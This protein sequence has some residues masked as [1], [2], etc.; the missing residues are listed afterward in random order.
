MY[1]DLTAE[2][3]KS[4]LIGRLSTDIQVNEGSYTNDMISAVAYE[5]W[6]VYQSLDALIPIA[7]VDSTSGEYID[8]RCSEYGI[9]RKA[10]TSAKAKLNFTGT[11][12]T[13]IPAGTVF[14]TADGL[15]FETDETVTITAGVATVNTTAVEIG[16]GY[17]VDV[18]TITQKLISLSGLSTVTNEKATGGTDPE[19]DTALVKRLNDYLQSP[20][21][22]GNVAHY[23]Q[24]ALSVNGVGAV[25]VHPLWDGPGTVKV[26]IVD[27]EKKPVDLTI[28][29]NCAEYIESNRPIG[30]TVT[31]ESAQ[32]LS[33]NIT[34]TIIID[35]STTLD[36]VK[37]EFEANLKVY[38]KD[39]SFEK[40]TIVYNRIVYMLLDIS[41][42]TDY[43]SLT[44][45]GGTANITIAENQV[46]VLQNVE[47]IT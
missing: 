46:P 20:A 47:V 40:Y 26:L 4:D 38:L 22:S 45:N 33:V 18:G 7:F 31:V 15:Q 27:N 24:W 39:L 25:K 44:I 23:K 8:K 1:E 12:G 19:T 13:L 34:A 9:I 2:S 42:V 29:N 5:I 28:L 11:D 32:E 16:E 43:T 17:N 36:I 6:K 3:I 37:A 10:G 21:T 14:L 41:G 35:S 30:A